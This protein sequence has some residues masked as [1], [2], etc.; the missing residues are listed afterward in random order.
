MTTSAY[1]RV[2]FWDGGGFLW[3]CFLCL[4]PLFLSLFFFLWLFYPRSDAWQRFFLT[5]DAFSSKDLRPHFG[6]RG[7]PNINNCRRWI[8]RPALLKCALIE[9][10][11]LVVMKSL[12]RALQRYQNVSPAHIFSG[13]PCCATSACIMDQYEHAAVRSSHSPLQHAS[14]L[15]WH[16]DKGQ[17]WYIYHYARSSP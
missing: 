5:S 9:M 6:T 17:S 13:N 15:G 7:C 14:Y 1:L 3:G 8:C 12:L 16:L 11:T 10:M 4:T 2:F